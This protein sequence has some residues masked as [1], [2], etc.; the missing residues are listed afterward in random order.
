MDQKIL[1][2]YKGAKVLSHVFL[3]TCLELREWEVLKRKIG[4]QHQRSDLLPQ[5]TWFSNS[6][7]LDATPSHSA[8]EMRTGEERD[9]GAESRNQNKP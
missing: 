5:E 1:N 2:Y 6:L 8:G 9:K 3:V 7:H 4:K